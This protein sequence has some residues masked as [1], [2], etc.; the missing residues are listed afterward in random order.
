MFHGPYS[1][2][3][4]KTVTIG[5]GSANYIEINENLAWEEPVIVICVGGTTIRNNDFLQ[6]CH[7]ASCGCGVWNKTVQVVWPPFCTAW[8]VTTQ[9]TMA[10]RFDNV[11]QNSHSNQIKRRF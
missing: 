2:R 9:T 7:G 4:S 11:N 1:R 6:G 3:V 8:A 10:R 5:G